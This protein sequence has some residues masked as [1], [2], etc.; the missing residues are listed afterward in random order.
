MLAV[1][2]VALTT[3]TITNCTG[4]F[5]VTPDLMMQLLNEPVWWLN[6]SVYKIIDPQTVD[7]VPYF[8]SGDLQ[9]HDVASW[10][11]P[12]I[13]V[14]GT[15]VGGLN[16]SCG[17]YQTKTSLATKLLQR[18]RLLNVGPPPLRCNHFEISAIS[19]GHT[20]LGNRP[21]KETAIPHIQT[22]PTN[23]EFQKS[24]KPDPIVPSAS[25]VQCSTLTQVC[26]TYEWMYAT[27]STVD[28]LTWYSYSGCQE[29]A[30]FEK[31]RANDVRVSHAWELSLPSPIQ[32][33]SSPNNVDFQCDDFSRDWQG[34]LCLNVKVNSVCF[35]DGCNAF[36]GY[37]SLKAWDKLPPDLERT[38]T[39]DFALVGTLAGVGV[40]LSLVIFASM[41]DKRQK[42]RSKS[43]KIQEQDRELSPSMDDFVWT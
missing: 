36:S 12:I 25:I 23:S 26:V 13:E 2:A 4:R 43:N 21:H 33:G 9:L 19:S 24:D 14:V 22:G 18:T 27:T 34:V 28:P 7:P 41:I 30:D 1:V 32:L 15:V 5:E 11:I 35:S 42:E 8:C 10:A 17:L 6:Y 40:V 39:F 16:K 37:P 29:E 38:D 3:P 20:Y 31:N